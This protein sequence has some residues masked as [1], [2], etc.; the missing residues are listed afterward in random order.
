MARGH[1]PWLRDSCLRALFPCASSM[2]IMLQLPQHSALACPAAGRRRSA[3]SAS[4]AAAAAAAAP[5]A[6]GPAPA[7][8]AGGGSLKRVSQPWNSGLE[9]SSS[10]SSRQPSR[11]MP[12]LP[13][14]LP[15][16][17]PPGWLPAW[18]LMGR[19]QRQSSSRRRSWLG[20]IRK[21]TT[22][23]LWRQRPAAGRP[24]SSAECGRQWH[25]RGHAHESLTCCPRFC[26]CAQCQR[27]YC[28]AW[29]LVEAA[30]CAGASNRCGRRA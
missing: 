24:T 12:M 19:R 28:L 17:Q 20:T 18:R 14:P 26:L 15:G 30:L 8:S 1:M 2:G 16:R 7:P 25:C 21:L 10:S 6:Q 5:L 29:L 3:R 4:A 9:S 13:K 11:L 23:A 27:Q 22:G